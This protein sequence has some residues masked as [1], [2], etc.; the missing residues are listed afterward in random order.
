MSMYTNTR[1]LP[2]V[3]LHSRAA[4]TNEKRADI[5][6]SVGT[7]TKRAK[8]ECVSVASVYRVDSATK[9]FGNSDRPDTR[10]AGR[11][12]VMTEKEAS[13][14]FWY[15]SIHNTASIESCIHFL[16]L[17]FPARR[18][19]NKFSRTLISKEFA[20]LGLKRH[21]VRAVSLLRDEDDRVAFW[22]SSINF[23]HTTQAAR[24]RHCTPHAPHTTHTAHCTHHMH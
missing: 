9:R 18:G 14:L 13:V 11:H 7:V 5:A 4:F 15:K 17:I 19:K 8:E 16:A 1:V 6:S 3:T 23:T 22:V 10:P 12:R 20:R 21:R 24:H 2:R